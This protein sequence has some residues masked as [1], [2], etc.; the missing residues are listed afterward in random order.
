[1]KTYCDTTCCDECKLKG[2]ACPGCRETDG[3]PCGGH[4][5]AAECV[6][7]GGLKALQDCKESI[8]REINALGI[9]DLRV[10]GL[11][12]LNGAFVNLEY[13]LPSGQKTKLLDD[14]NVYWGNQVERPGQERCYG[15]VAD[16]WHLL[17]CEYGCEGADPKI[18]L[19][20]RR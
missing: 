19:F 16:E 4:C 13:T 10:D 7:A 11:H 9:P 14:R 18:V 3:H 5:V 2:T 17:V 1:M 6:R 15:I 8:I 20:K 12:L